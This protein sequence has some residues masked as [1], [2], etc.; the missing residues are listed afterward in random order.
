M[1]IRKTLFALAIVST[2]TFTFAFAQHTST[3]RKQPSQVKRKTAPATPTRSRRV[4]GATET[5]DAQTGAPKP[6]TVTSSATAEPSPINSPSPSESPAPAPAAAETKPTE[7]SPAKT[8]TTASETRS[9]AVSDPITAL[10]AQIDA[11]ATPQDRIRLQLKLAEELSGN[12]KK[13]EAAAELRAI[14]GSDVF[15]PQGLYNTGNALARLGDTEGAVNAYRKAI[16]QRKGG[17]SRA[18]NNLGVVL[19]RVGRWD[20]AEDAFLSALRVENFHYA[21]AS[22]NLGRLYATRGQMDLAVREWRRAV[23]VDPDHAAAAQSL[24]RSGNEGRIT[25]EQARG[26]LKNTSASTAAAERQP[27]KSS[28]SRASEKP[29]VLDPT[30]FGYLQRARNASE[31]GN[32]TEA[33][34]NYQ[35]VIARQ[36][37]YF[38]P[39]N[40]E[41]SYV[42][43][44]LKRNNEALPRLL[45]VVNRE[46]S[47]YPI[48]YYHIARIYE[49]KGELKLAEDAFT[50]A[51][52]A[53]GT[54]NSQFLLDLS[55]VREKQG[56]FKGALEAMEQYVA[57]VKKEGQDITWSEE[58]VIALR[59][60]AGTPLR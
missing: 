46:G 5:A 45:E 27:A 17:Y 22:Y 49:G 55:R 8:A 41:L 25:V 60:K 40:L 57:L 42:L 59:Q 19:L 52:A 39:A 56:N 15:D 7:K 1:S 16:E 3:K 9:Q 28:S 33:I 35:R 50:Q 30:S 14:T 58:R 47:R 54:K 4:G 11:A 23:T 37:G 31:R 13:T 48:G 51:V 6:A 21:E 32:K 12:G 18:L 2:L 36:D 29:L 44:G 26:V 53:Y 20:E 24:A 43:I 10:R 34:D 38:G